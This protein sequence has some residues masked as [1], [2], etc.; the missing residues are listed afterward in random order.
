MSNIKFEV[1]STAELNIKQ[2]IIDNQLFMLNSF[3]ELKAGFTGQSVFIIA[4]GPSVKDFPI[5]KFKNYPIITMNSSQR[6]AV[7]HGISPLFYLCNDVNAA[8][9]NELF[10]SGISTAQYTALNKEV[11]LGVYNNFN[12]RFNK[13]FLLERVNRLHNHKKLNNFLFALRNRFSRELVVYPSLFNKHLNRIGFSKNIAKGYFCCRTIP[14]VAIQL[15]YYLRF[16]NIFLVGVDMND[17]Q[18][19][20]HDDLTSNKKSGVT[21]YFKSLI[22]PSFNLLSKHLISNDFN[23]YNLSKA[24]SIPDS[25]IP[26]VS[27]SDI[28]VLLRK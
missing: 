10:F 6:I 8:R 7:D 3:A 15:A 25:I 22:M 18:Y 2:L 24:S 28:E 23:I 27:V 20:Y 4:S 19:F 5:E 1:N 12:F 17:N 16:K 13:L 9:N 21:A 14:Y 26:K 11:L